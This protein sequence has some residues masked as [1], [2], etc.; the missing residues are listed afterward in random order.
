VRDARQQEAR[1]AIT[2]APAGEWLAGLEV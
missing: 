1:G 2:I